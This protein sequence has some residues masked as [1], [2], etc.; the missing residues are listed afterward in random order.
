M[1][2]EFAYTMIICTEHHNVLARDTRSTKHSCI[3]HDTRGLCFDGAPC[4]ALEKIHQI[5]SR[6][7]TKAWTV[8]NDMF[9]LP[10]SGGLLEMPIDRS[11][12]NGLWT[13]TAI[14]RTVVK[15]EKTIHRG[16]CRYWQ[17]RNASITAKTLICEDAQPDHDQPAMTVLL[18]SYSQI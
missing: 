13:L 17:P 10:T 18:Q 16:V 2:G 9:H 7:M 12:F 14:P 5:L 3:G 1:F 6:T 4:L 8:Q 11:R 15:H